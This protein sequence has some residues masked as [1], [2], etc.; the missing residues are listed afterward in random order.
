MNLP[1][2]QDHARSVLP[3]QPS[4]LTTQVLHLPPGR[5]TS[6]AIMRT[7]QPGDVERCRL[8]DGRCAAT[9]NACLVAVSGIVATS[10]ARML[11][12]R[13]YNRQPEPETR[14]MAAV[15]LQ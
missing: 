13:D 1:S 3:L 6:T 9:N 15:T 4:P 7:W 8:C 14:R 5:P 2:A 12:D 10:D 11:S